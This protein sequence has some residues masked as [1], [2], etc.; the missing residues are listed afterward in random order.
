MLRAFLEI[1]DQAICVAVAV[2][3]TGCVFAD[4]EACIVPVQVIV[5]LDFQNQLI[6][7]AEFSAWQ[8]G[9][10]FPRSP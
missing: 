3:P 9:A 6:D 8:A 7:L 10:S 4:V 1:E 5:L 2:T